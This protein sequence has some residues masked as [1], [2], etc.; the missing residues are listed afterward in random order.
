MV[1]SIPH[2]GRK[3]VFLFIDVLNTFSYGYMAL[4]I[5]GKGPFTY[6]ERKP[7]AATWATLSN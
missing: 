6:R 1:R 2:M 4:D 7:A 5:I 3:E